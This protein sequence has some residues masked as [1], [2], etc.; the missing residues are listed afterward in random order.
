MP[1]LLDLAPE[2]LENIAQYLLHENDQAHMHL[3]ALRLSCRPV[4]AA[5][6]RIFRLKYFRSVNIRKPKDANIEKFCAISKVPDLAKS[7]W[8]IG[9][10]CA[11]DGTAEHDARSVVRQR[12]SPQPSDDTVELLGRSRADQLVPAALISHKEALLT[13]LLATENVMMLEFADCHWNL[14]ASDDTEREDLDLP[15]PRPRSGN[16]LLGF[17]CDISSTFK[18]IMSLIARAGLAPKWISIG[19]LHDLKSVTGLTTA[20]GLVTYKQALLQLKSLQLVFV[21]ESGSDEAV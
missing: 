14:S 15:A 11:D 17:V 7:I 1:S 13:A 12:N 3:A 19:S 10:C 8:R 6:R 20:I 21:N 5:I 18:F 2:L 16:G 4:E 9:I